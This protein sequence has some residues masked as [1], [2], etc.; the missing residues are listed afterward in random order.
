MED[1]PD[2]R[3]QIFHNTVR[4][5]VIFLLL[6]I[7]LYVSA[8]AV[9]ARFRRRSSEDYYAIDEEEATVFKISLWLCTFSLAVSLGAALLLPISILSNEILALYPSSYYVQW[10]NHSLVQGMWCNIFLF[11]NLSLFAFL[12]FAYLFTESEGFPGC[13]KGI[14]ARV[15][16]TFVILVLLGVT[17]LGMT[18]VIASFFEDQHST[19]MV[20]FNLGSYYLPFLYSCISFIGALILL[21]C[22]PL[23]FERLFAVVGNLLVKPQ[24]LRD[25]EVEFYVALLEEHTLEQRLARTRASGGRGYLCPAP[26]SPAGALAEEPPY[27]GLQN[28]ELQ[29]GI[30]TRLEDVRRHRKYLEELCETSLLQRN[31]LYP[32]SMLLL[33]ALTALAVFMVAQNTLG[34]LVG[35]KALPLSQEDF[36][37]GLRP[38]SKLGPVGALLEIA[39]ICYLVATSSVGVY[40]LPGLRRVKPRRAR[41]PFTHVVANCALLLV[42]SSALPLLARILGFTNFDL[43]G[44]FGKIRWLGNM[45]IVLL[46]NVGFGGCAALCLANRFTAKVRQELWSCWAHVFEHVTRPC[47]L[48]FA[49]WAEIAKSLDE[50]SLRFCSSIGIFESNEP[51]AHEKHRIRTTSLSG[52]GLKEE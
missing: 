45:E 26:M 2:A 28:G 7:L 11:S 43:L 3:E 35:I 36:I 9:I 25:L 15:H 8:F 30:E 47:A 24:F 29:A 40:T 44:D 1:D 34:L 10:L 27:V 16:E 50:I 4:E 41:T 21:L 33:V 51:S 42:L 31:I 17:V 52:T 6:F 19:I 46:Y 12:P 23:G 39:L 32:A 20:M 38:L 22:T 49:C 18:Y 14:M 13:R 37:L 5:Y 48:T